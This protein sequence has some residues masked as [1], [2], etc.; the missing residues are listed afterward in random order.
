MLHWAPSVNSGGAL[1]FLDQVL[2]ITEQCLLAIHRPVRPEALDQQLTAQERQEVGRLMR[3]NHVGEVCAQG[4]YLGAECAA[5]NTNV[6]KMMNESR[7]E[8]IPHMQWLERRLGQLEGR[9]SYALPVWFSA[10]WAM[11]YV[12]GLAGDQWSLGFVAETEKQVVVHLEDHLSRLPKH[13][14]ESHRVLTQILN[15]ELAHQHEAEE[16]GA[17]QL[18]DWIQGAMAVAAEGMRRVV[19]WL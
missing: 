16:M 8:E 17:K 4:L 18:P 9:V 5:K 3:I 14:M 12:A 10:S 13:D 1:S 2:T 7:Q 19:R 15:E 11:G 6:A